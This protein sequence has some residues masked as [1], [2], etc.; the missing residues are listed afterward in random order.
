ML[1]ET[2]AA[3][4]SLA[5]LEAGVAAIDAGDLRAHVRFL[6]SDELQGRALGHPGNEVAALYLAS[7]FERAGIT[8]EA[9][10][11]QRFEVFTSSL[12]PSSSL[13]YP[14]AAAPYLV[15]KDFYPLHDS[16]QGTVTAPLISAGYGISAPELSYDDYEGIDA[17]G[18]IVVVLDH[19]PE[20]GEVG[21]GFAGRGRTVH[22]HPAKK[23]ETAAA[24]GA[25]GLLLVP[26][27][28][29]HPDQPPRLD[30]A[31][32]WPNSPAP[33]DEWYFPSPDSRSTFVSAMIS[34]SLAR[35]LSTRESI[36]LVSAVKRQSLQA[37]NVVGFVEGSDP[38]LRQELV[39]VGAHFDHEG[40]DS[41]GAIYNGA[42]DDASGTAGV[43]EVAEAFSR[44]SS[45]GILPK[46]T[47]VFGLWNG[48]ER[49]LLGSRHYA[50]RPLPARGRP[51]AY[52]N[53]DMIGR[54]EEVPD[55]ADSSF[56]GLE[57]TTAAENANVI[58]M[59]GHKLSPDLARRVERENQAIGLVI[60]KE[61][62]SEELGFL[63]SS[64]HWAFLERGIPSVFL[65]TGEH[66]EVHTP[67]DDV[68]RIDFP[69]MERIVRLAFLVIWSLANE[70]REAP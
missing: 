13:T 65:Y 57:R 19:E 26:D 42:D 10:Y 24:R 15:G 5:Q 45:S 51:V 17:T 47:V 54:S 53:L 56:F 63:R 61:R 4:S 49:G 8:G 69:K 39:I 70:P 68:E 16:P 7:V 11:F 43:L 38:S 40:L 1:A 27:E 58:H 2:L 52:L 48:E 20:E 41:E 25:V 12:G 55:P 14:G 18:K 62:D 9:D 50:S 3:L 60:K 29:S 66:P 36:T 35:E 28:S 37:R 31:G 67:L 59:I 33:R 6:A 44:L 64:D 46:R 30:A 22:A 23:I 21:A 32:Y 34:P